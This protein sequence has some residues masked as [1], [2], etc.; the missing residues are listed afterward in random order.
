MF[1]TGVLKVITKLVT[2]IDYSVKQQQARLD[3][4]FKEHFS[5]FLLLVIGYK[6]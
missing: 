4:Y 1:S 2:H 5:C 3:F 6:F